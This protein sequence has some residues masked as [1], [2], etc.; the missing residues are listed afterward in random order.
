MADI[1]CPG[2]DHLGSL[3]SYSEGGCGA[4]WEYD[5]DGVSKADGC[6]CPWALAQ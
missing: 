4:N 6:M 1:L 3:H 2:C 5:K